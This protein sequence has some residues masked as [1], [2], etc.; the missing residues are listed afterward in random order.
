MEARLKA[1]DRWIV[2]G[3]LSHA[4]RAL[5]ECSK[6]KITNI[7]QAIELASLYRRVDW[8]TQGVKVLSPFVVGRGRSQPQAN[9]AAKIEYA[10][11]LKNLGLLA[12]ARK[13]LH[14]SDIQKNPKAKFILGLSYLHDYELSKAEELLLELHTSNESEFSHY[15]HQV[16][17]VNLLM[18]MLRD[19]QPPT[20]QNSFQQI[21]RQTENECTLQNYQL[22]LR[23][24]SVIH[25]QFKVLAKI[26]TKRDLQ[27]QLI[28]EDLPDFSRK[29]AEL[30]LMMGKF[31]TKEID[32]K[33]FICL[34]NEL[35]KECNSLRLFEVVREI[36]FHRARLNNQIHLLQKTVDQ[37][38][39]PC[40]RK[41]IINI[42]AQ[43]K[44][45][46]PWCLLEDNLS[47]DAS[48]IFDLDLRF[49]KD[50]PLLVRTLILMSRERYTPLSTH[51]LWNSLMPDRHFI[52]PSSRQSIHQLIKRLRRFFERNE[53]PL[54]VIVDQTGYRLAVNSKTKVRLH[55][56]ESWKRIELQ[57]QS[58][59]YLDFL[60]AIR[61][62]FRQHSHFQLA[63][64][65]KIFPAISKRT[66]Q[67]F[68][69][70]AT[71]DNSIEKTG[72]N[73][74]TRYFWDLTLPAK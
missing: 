27:A 37:T 23:H 66:L 52:E 61:L 33:E 36:D 63:E 22:L 15:Q 68:L 42:S 12:E 48:N 73:K 1:I 26:I 25:L 34:S 32:Q 72:K 40:Y 67:F 2:A 54:Q 65:M 41:K 10:D 43:I 35:Q 39:F 29:T 69:V 59:A 70:K 45:E 64:V 24:L 31:L 60:A 4:K 13:I 3:K 19:V 8:N 57:N 56:P 30:Y 16:I 14:A 5:K 53:V 6:K 49:L 9:A 51:F 44:E 47:N 18:A 71:S 38:S 46:R 11:C 17:G 62:Y 50:E 7:D 21:L 28:L 58:L 55:W 74:G 20:R